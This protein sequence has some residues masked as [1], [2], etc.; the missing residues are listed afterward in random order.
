VTAHEKLQSSSG[1]N[2]SRNNN[3]T[4]DTEN[5]FLEEIK[6][7]H[8]KIMQKDFLA[9]QLTRNFPNNNLHSTHFSSAMSVNSKQST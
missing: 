7:S 9:P 6:D 3:L 1:Y 5:K 4:Y 8:L 2:T